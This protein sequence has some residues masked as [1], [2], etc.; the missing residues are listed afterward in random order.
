MAGLCHIT[1]ENI[2]SKTSTKTAT[3]KLVP[4]P[5][6]F[7]KNYTPSVL[8]NENFEAS[9]LYDKGNSKTIKICSNQ[10]EDQLRFIFKN[11]L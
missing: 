4:D 7:A 9:H 8:V 6:M 10:D 11:D 1:K 5:F 2:L 3:W